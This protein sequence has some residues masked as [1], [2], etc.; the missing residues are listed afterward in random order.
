MVRARQAR[1]EAHQRV[2]LADGTR[3]R[4][5]AQMAVRYGSF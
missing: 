5:M 2:H 4:M 1:T 3:E